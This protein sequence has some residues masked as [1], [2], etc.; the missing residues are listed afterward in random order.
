MKL[1]NIT[2]IH[3]IIFF[4]M[5]VFSY[6]LITT[7]LYG[8][9]V[10][11]SKKKILTNKKKAK[12]QNK[13]IKSKQHISKITSNK[14]INK[15]GKTKANTF[16]VTKDSLLDTGIHY[17]IYQSGSKKSIRTVHIVEADLD[18]QNVGIEVLKAGK[19]CNVLERLHDM[20]SHHDSTDSGRVIAAVNGNFW[21]AYSNF[22]IGP[23]VVNGE[24]IE[25]KKHRNWSSGF[26]D[27]SG[28]LYIDN[29]ALNCGFQDRNGKG[30][31]F[32]GTNRRRD[33]SGIILYTCFAGDT[34]PYIPKKTL[35]CEFVDY[36]Q[37]IDN[38]D[39]TEAPCDTLKLRQEFLNSQRSAMTEYSL[40]KL[41]LKY[42][43]TPTINNKVRCKLISI[44][45]G[46]VAIPSYGCVISF[47]KNEF[48]KDV[49]KIGDTVRLNFETD[50]YRE[51]T[52]LNA[53]SGTPRL[54]RSGV[55]G[56][57]AYQEGCH[58][59][60]FI[61]RGLPRT[62]IGTNKDKTRIY[63][64]AVEPA[65]SRRDTGLNLAAMAEL[66]KKIGCYDAMNL[67]GGGSTVMVINNKNVL[68]KNN[69]WHSR[70]VAIGVSII[71]DNGSK[72]KTR[73]K[74]LIFPHLPAKSNDQE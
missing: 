4:I 18:E 73:N 13:S 15:K 5:L 61:N 39:S 31:E 17:K 58:G 44:D 67:D 37:D 69:P 30:Y 59:K 74:A 23:A 60:R 53:I 71:S 41:S 25:F 19:H 22:P 72:S 7:D 26:F 54:V 55:A 42:I 2:I 14:K 36:L 56:Q 47:G 49:F 34:I 29:F 46:A 3:T 66:M 50:R 8:S 68:I 6:E 28:R 12:I 70:K 20:I 24:V 35:E 51:I 52:F 64:A 10:K 21:R 27:E 1:K 45:T 57:E 11:T 48:L 32:D 38:E 65:A 16:I 40:T 9:S 63:L 43:D 62:S 33:T